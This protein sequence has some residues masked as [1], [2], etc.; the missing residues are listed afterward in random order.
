VYGFV[1]G[2]KEMITGFRLVGIEGVEI[3]TV[4]EAKIALSKAIE[5][6]DIAIVVISEEWSSKIREE[7]DRQRSNNV[8]PL[9]VEIP[10][11][12]GPKGEIRL[13]ELV[14]KSLGIKI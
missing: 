3:S 9:I 5:N 11:R 4:E 14:S 2:D 7:I 6:V 12:R 10:G 13:V 8:S 1:I